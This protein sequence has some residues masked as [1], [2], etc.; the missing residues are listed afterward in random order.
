MKREIK[1]KHQYQ[2]L[3]LVVEAEDINDLPR[4]YKFPVRLPIATGEDV[5]SADYFDKHYPRDNEQMFESED[6]RRLF[7]AFY[8]DGHR[9]MRYE[10]A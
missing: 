9:Q 5:T 1:I 2:P 3:T 4:T 10:P 6:D 7:I 8:D